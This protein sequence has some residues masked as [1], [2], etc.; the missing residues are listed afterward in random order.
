MTLDVTGPTPDTETETETEAEADY[1]GLA[2]LFGN[3]QFAV[4]P[5]RKGDMW[6]HQPS[7]LVLAIPE[8]QTSSNWS[9]HADAIWNASIFLA[10]HLHLLRD[11]HSDSTSKILELGCGGGLLGN[12]SPTPTPTPTSHKL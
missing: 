4:I 10:E 12:N 8:V 9:L 6:T 1:D 5:K 7:G 11:L 2:Q 3:P